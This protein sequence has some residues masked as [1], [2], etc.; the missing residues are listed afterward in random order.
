LT[1]A[2]VSWTSADDVARSL[3]L[4][5]YAGMATMK[6]KFLRGGAGMSMSDGM[7]PATLPGRDVHDAAPGGETTADAMPL[8]RRPMPVTTDGFTCGDDQPMPGGMDPQTLPGR[9]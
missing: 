8:R 2:F 5:Y 7:G 3:A 4:G 6:P 1:R 9:S